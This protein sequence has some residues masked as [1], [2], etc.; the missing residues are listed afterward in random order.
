MSGGSNP[1][2]L[3]QVKPFFRSLAGPDQVN[4]LVKPSILRQAPPSLSVNQPFILTSPR[5]CLC[6]ALFLLM[7]VESHLHVLLSKVPSHGPSLLLN[8]AWT[9]LLSPWTRVAAA[10]RT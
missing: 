5:G 2:K 1:S 8:P 6:E 9:L 3:Y 10:G 4:V 7:K